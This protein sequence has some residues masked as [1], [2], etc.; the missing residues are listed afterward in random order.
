MRVVVLN[1]RHRGERNKGPPCINE[2]APLPCHS[3]AF[4]ALT[5]E[6]LWVSEI[7]HH[8]LTL[9]GYLAEFTGRDMATIT[10]DTDR[11]FFMSAKVPYSFVH[12]LVALPTSS[13]PGC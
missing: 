4:A 2:C 11:D 9:N 12:T 1:L 8:K 5:R 7:L 6:R 10:A 13:L 3:P